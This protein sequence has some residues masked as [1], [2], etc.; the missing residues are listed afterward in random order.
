[1]A[2]LTRRNFATGALTLVAG[3]CAIKR[4]GYVDAV[5]E[6]PPPTD[7]PV[8]RPRVPP[9][10]VDPGLAFSPVRTTGAPPAVVWSWTTTEQADELRRDKVLFTRESSPTLGRGL[11]FDVI[12]E[13]AAKGDAAAARLAG[14][15][16]AKGRFGWSNPW[17]TVRGA[18]SD[19]T[20]G[21]E[22][23]RIEMRADTWYA[24]VR[25]SDVA[26][27]FVDAR[28]GAIATDTALAS[29]DRVGGIVFE[30]DREVERESC[31]TGSGGG[32]IVYREIYVGNEARLAAVSHRTQ[33][34]L[35][36]LEARIDELEAFRLWLAAP[37][38]P[39][40]SWFAWA[41]NAVAMWQGE[42][43]DTIDRYVGS[44]AFATEAYR[45]TEPNIAAI[46]EEL[47]KRRFVPDP[48]THAGYPG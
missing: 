39:S 35:G 18:T 9:P 31:S 14:I 6:D 33:E 2:R 32:G 23:L 10:P 19:E 8:E 47:R 1:M 4:P 37:G 7:G 26:I 21:D 17:A 36:V 13:R 15:E 30:H 22:L 11:L 44:L 41:C 3:S 45:P 42:P 27:E 34:I 5:E 28:G 25:S 29:F 24:R 43:V 40:A 46:V 48:F 38:S 20:Y 12:E 16:L